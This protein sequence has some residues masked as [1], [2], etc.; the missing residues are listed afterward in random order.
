[1]LP[2]PAPPPAARLVTGAR[3]V[4]VVDDNIDAAD[5]LATLLTT[6]GCEVA[7]AFD[8]LQ[9]LQRADAFIPQIVLL[10]LGL[11]KMNGYDVCRA[12]RQ[13]YGNA[14]GIV[15]MTGWGQDEDRRR[16]REAGFDLHLV[17]PVDPDVLVDALNAHAAGAGAGAGGRAAVGDVRAAG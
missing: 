9:A 12:L 4:L 16:S 8:G 5:T 3:R 10:D 15:A 1:V 2:P 13:R 11:P 7:T 6:L 14:L 17:K